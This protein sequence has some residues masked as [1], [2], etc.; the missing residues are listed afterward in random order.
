MTYHRL[1]SELLSPSFA[2]MS[3][4]DRLHLDPARLLSD[5]FLESSDLLPTGV[6]CL[7]D[8]CVL[9]RNSVDALHIDRVAST[10][11]IVYRYRPYPKRKAFGSVKEAEESTQ[12]PLM[13][14]E[15]VKDVAQAVEASL[16]Q[17]DLDL[18]HAI[19]ESLK[20]HTNSTETSKRIKPTDV[21]RSGASRELVSSLTEPRASTSSSTWRKY[22]DLAW[23]A[24]KETLK[25]GDS[26]AVAAVVRNC[27]SG[28]ISTGRSSSLPRF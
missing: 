10:L 2:F 24:Q 20:D 15:E 12:A 8:L 21:G 27:S 19:A 13:A 5:A 18:A 14:A 26:D 11:E 3:L 7:N 25:R 6:R 28:S 16:H 17:E 4:W 1:L 9:W 22:P 23:V